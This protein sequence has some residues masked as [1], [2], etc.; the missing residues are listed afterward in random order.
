MW[1]F[2]LLMK[3][4]KTAHICPYGCGRLTPNAYKG[5]TELLKDHPNYFK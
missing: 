4:R 2:L 3:Y 5:C 1:S